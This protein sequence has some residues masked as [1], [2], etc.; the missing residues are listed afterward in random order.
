MANLS[1]VR[2][3]SPLRTDCPDSE[4]GRSCFQR[5]H[6]GLVQRRTERPF[7]KR[8]GNIA[9]GGWRGEGGGIASVVCRDLP[10]RI[11]GGVSVKRIPAGESRRQTPPA[12][13]ATGAVNL[14][15]RRS[16]MGFSRLLGASWNKAPKGGKKR[17]AVRFSRASS[18]HRDLRN[19]R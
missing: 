6:T 19:A 1:I 7:T 2:G 13:F 9:E 8:G 4:G 5:R 12:G 17:L 15:K 16:G 10:A 11:G 14:G 3:R 18:L